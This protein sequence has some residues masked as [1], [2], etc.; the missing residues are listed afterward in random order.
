MARKPDNT[1]PPRAV[2]MAISDAEAV[3]QELSAA[4]VRLLVV[5]TAALMALDGTTR[6]SASS[7]AEAVLN[8]HGVEVSPSLVGQI[9]ADLRTPSVTS[10]ARRRLVL[11][12]TGLLP[13]RDRVAAEVE[14]QEA[15]ARDTTERFGAVADRVAA[16]EISL[17]RALRLA[18][19][20]REIRDSLG[21]DRSA[22]QRLAAWEERYRTLR[23]QLARIE[24]LEAECAALR[25]RV[26]GLPA[27]E[28]E[29]R[30]LEDSL[31]SRPRRLGPSSHVTRITSRKEGDSA[32][33]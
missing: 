33:S 6:A 7:V 22:D 32:S 25:E 23:A 19:R 8:E 20:E 24:R 27:L 11:D 28:K 2:D 31:R 18:R 16:L 10:H 30:D 29:K 4:R 3:A 1:R 15:K 12:P 21:A 26:K 14:A 5:Q 17:A 13:I 9:L